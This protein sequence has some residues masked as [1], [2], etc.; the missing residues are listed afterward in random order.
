M[1]ILTVFRLNVSVP[2]CLSYLRFFHQGVGSFS[3][4]RDCETLR[5]FVDSSNNILPFPP[6]LAHRAHTSLVV[7]QW[8]QRVLVVVW[9]IYKV[10]GTNKLQY[11]GPGP[12]WS[13]GW[14]WSRPVLPSPTETPSSSRGQ[15]VGHTSDHP[16]IPTYR[17][18]CYVSRCSELRRHY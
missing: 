18:V 1:I 13:W 12:S 5:S 9:H 7:F 10:A 11:S 8:Q 17:H 4:S 3:I 16:T 2:Q 6:D 15:Y 14:Q